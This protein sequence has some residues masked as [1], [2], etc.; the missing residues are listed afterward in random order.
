MGILLEPMGTFTLLM[1]N[2]RFAELDDPVVQRYLHQLRPGN[3]LHALIAE[4]SREHLSVLG[5]A[6]TLHI[7]ISLEEELLKVHLAAP[8][9]VA[10]E[11]AEDRLFAVALACRDHLMARLGAALQVVMAGKVEGQELWQEEGTFDGDVVLSLDFLQRAGVQRQGDQTDSFLPVVWYEGDEQRVQSLLWLG[12]DEQRPYPVLV[13]NTTVSLYEQHSSNIAVAACQE[14]FMRLSVPP[15]V[16]P[17]VGQ[18]WIAGRTLTPAL[19]IEPVQAGNVPVVMIQTWPVFGPMTSTL[20]RYLLS[21]SFGQ[22]QDMLQR[23]GVPLEPEF[24]PPPS[25]GP[26]DRLWLSTETLLKLVGDEF[27]WEESRRN[28]V[29]CQ[30]NVTLK[31]ERAQPR[32]FLQFRKATDSLQLG[33]AFY[34]RFVDEEESGYPS[35]ALRAHTQG[36]VAK[37]RLEQ[38]VAHH[39]EHLHLQ[40]GKLLP[41][42]VDRDGVYLRIDAQ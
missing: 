42:N 26:G 37:G 24:I 20:L 30:I 22:F 12:A 2:L 32:K 19:L 15:E 4:F 1:L 29:S 34:L 40:M 17:Q 13:V 27:T 28:E 18:N 14:H 41:V 25:T 38:V 9:P 23:A 6:G 16:L 10:L 7:D 31:N 8:D 5:L 33:V 11:E 36:G 39:L 3:P 35:L 21:T